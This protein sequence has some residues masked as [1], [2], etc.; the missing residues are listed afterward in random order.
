MALLRLFDAV[1][2]RTPAGPDS[3]TVLAAAVGAAYLAVVVGYGVLAGRFP[4]VGALLSLG[5]SPAGGLLVRLAGTVGVVLLGAAPVVL[6]QRAGLV[7][8]ALAPVGLPAWL[9]TTS[10]A[11][12]FAVLVFFYTPFFLAGAVALG[13][14]EYAVRRLLV[15]PAL[16]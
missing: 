6:Y 15:A 16:G 5:D 14:V 9:A 7:L 8:P 13:G 1:Y 10:G 12:S 2:D 3:S 4:S 11:E